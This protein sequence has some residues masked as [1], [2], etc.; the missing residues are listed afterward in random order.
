MIDG[1]TIFSKTEKNEVVRP[2]ETYMPI[3]YVLVIVLVACA[4][5]AMVWNIRHYEENLIPFIVM[6]SAL[7]VCL[8]TIW[9]GRRTE[10]VPTGTYRY[11]AIVDE[12]VTA[13]E[14]MNHYNI[15]DKDGDVWVLEDK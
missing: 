3:G 1:V 5:I 6:W 14:I 13:E 11:S 4:I 8:I 15:I 12:S 9:L 2:Y 7:I 10:F